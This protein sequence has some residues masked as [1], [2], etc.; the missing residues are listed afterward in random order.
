MCRNVE[1]SG[2]SFFLTGFTGLTGLGFSWSF[3]SGR[4][5]LGG[6]PVA[7]AR[8][9]G[10]SSREVRKVRKVF[11]CYFHCLE[12]WRFGRSFSWSGRLVPRPRERVNIHR[13]NFVGLQSMRKLVRRDEEFITPH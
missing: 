6:H 3:E 5:K 7:A 13:D 8:G 9:I 11:L 10:L 12:I 4:I 1:N 2:V